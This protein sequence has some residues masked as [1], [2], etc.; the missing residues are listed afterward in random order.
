MVLTSLLV[1]TIP[2]IVSYGLVVLRLV[3]FF[4]AVAV[5]CAIVGV[6][7]GS[8][9][10]PAGTL[11]VALVGMAPVLKMSGA[12]A[13][14]AVI[15]GGYMGDKMSPMSETTVRVPQ[16]V[17][18]VTTNQPIR[19]MLTTVVPS[20]GLAFAIFL[21]IGSPLRI[22]EHLGRPRRPSALSARRPHITTLAV[23]N[24]AV[25]TVLFLV[26]GVNL[27]AK[28]IALLTW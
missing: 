15:S 21:G 5:I 18:G 10:T 9:W 6:V 11:G 7:T 23:H 28:G 13:V 25:M 4:A 19:G 22:G 16:L 1:L 3:I 20:F 12:I 26:L 17:G 24:D 27:L 2:T 8:S 14:G